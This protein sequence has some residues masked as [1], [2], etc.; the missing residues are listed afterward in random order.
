MKSKSKKSG[1]RLRRKIS[2]KRS[3]NYRHNEVVEEKIF[4]I[5]DYKRFSKSV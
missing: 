3:G 4:I 5:I 1:I 2:Y